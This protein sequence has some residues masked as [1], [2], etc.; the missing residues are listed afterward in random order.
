[1]GEAQLQIYYRVGFLLVKL[2]TVGRTP[3]IKRQLLLFAVGRCPY[4]GGFWYRHCNPYLGHI[5]RA[6]S[7]Y[8]NEKGELEAKRR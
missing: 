1:M 4:F 6:L 5:I 7:C 2:S 8:A 3:Y